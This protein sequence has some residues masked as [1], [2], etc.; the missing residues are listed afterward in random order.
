M[1]IKDKIT[2]NFKIY[3]SVGESD[4][5]ISSMHNGKIIGKAYDREF[6]VNINEQ[7]NEIKFSF[8]PTKLIRIY[9]F[10]GYVTEISSNH[11]FFMAGIVG[12]TEIP[13]EHSGWYAVP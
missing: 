5:T 4:F 10:D 13:S 7:T 12:I 1:T 3:S 2:R 8:Q 9:N 6:E 11:Q